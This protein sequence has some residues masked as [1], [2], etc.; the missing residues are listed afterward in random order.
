MLWSKQAEMALVLLAVSDCAFCHYRLLWSC[1][2]SSWGSW[3]TCQSQQCLPRMPPPRGALWWHRYMTHLAGKTG[4]SSGPTAQIWWEAMFAFSFA[5]LG[6]CAVLPRAR[7]AK[8]P[9]HATVLERPEV[10]KDPCQSWKDTAARSGR[11]EQNKNISIWSSF[12]P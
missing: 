9:F 12:H 1:G 8:E 10:Q 3:G 11:R 5:F 4:S 2:L 6:F 7:K